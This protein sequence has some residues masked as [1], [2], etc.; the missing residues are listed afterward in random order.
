MPDLSTPD[1]PAMLA[2]STPVLSVNT[3]LAKR[4]L[5]AGTGSNVGKS[6]IVTGLM[7][8][9]YQ[10]GIAAAPFK[11]QN[12]ALNSAVAVDGGEVARAQAVQARAGGVRVEVAMNPVLIKPTGRERSQLIVKG[13]PIGE[14]ASG[15]WIAAKRGLLDTVVGAFEELAERY[16]IIIAEG[17]GSAGEINLLPGDLANLRL[18]KALNMGTVLVGDLEPGGV[19]ASIYGHY[20]LVSEE[21]RPLFRGFILN[22]VRGDGKILDRGIEE[23]TRRLG[24]EWFGN[25]PLIDGFL[26]GEDALNL[27]ATATSYASVSQMRGQ[28]YDRIQVRVVELPYLANYTDFDPLIVE[29]AIDLRFVTRPDELMDADLVILPGTKA[30][31]VALNWLRHSGIA[32]RLVELTDVGVWLLGICGGYQ[33]LVEEIDDEVESGVGRVAGLGLLGGGVVFGADKALAN[34]T[35]S[36][37]GFG[38]AGV[39]G[40][41]IHHGVV[42]TTEGP[43][44]MLG[45]VDGDVAQRSPLVAEG[46]CRGGQ[47]FGT[48]VHGLF[49][50]DEFRRSFFARLAHARQRTFVSTLCFDQFID[51]SLDNLADVLDS[52]LDVA[53]LLGLD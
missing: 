45:G 22:R 51:D 7:R 38:D 49:D 52:H 5:I 28:D 6:M 18:A 31:V 19:F 21:Y 40:Y 30:T 4:V 9:C 50:Q 16:Q 11:G 46:A 44:F 32:R 15:G 25:V 33:M 23:L 34:V 29:P 3:S 17:A 35:G 8:W 48:S 41:Q 53:H 1:V 36:S 14:I 20:L 12:M 42:K 24:T 27:G 26:P 47:V 37:P 10:R 13:R 39:R 43:L 2:G